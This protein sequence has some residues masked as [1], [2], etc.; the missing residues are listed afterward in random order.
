MNKNKREKCGEVFI[1][2]YTHLES[3]FSLIS[4]CFTKAC[5]LFPFPLPWFS[6]PFRTITQRCGRSSRRLAYMIEALHSDSDR[7]GQIFRELMP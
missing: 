3:D 2:P 1:V 7:S 4:D 6:R 5:A